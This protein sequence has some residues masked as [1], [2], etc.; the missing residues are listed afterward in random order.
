MQEPINEFDPRHPHERDGRNERPV[1]D[2]DGRC[3]VCCRDYH[4]AEIDRLTARVAAYER[5]HEEARKESG[6]VK[7]ATHEECMGCGCRMLTVSEIVSLLTARIA[8]LESQLA[9]VPALVDALR[10]IQMQAR[11][12]GYG[13][14]ACGETATAALAAFA[15][16]GGDAA[17]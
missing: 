13:K 3:L 4:T 10:K 7:C 17:A 1:F 14:G 2:K 11:A 12:T 16:E 6:L 8:A 5:E 15:K 9:G